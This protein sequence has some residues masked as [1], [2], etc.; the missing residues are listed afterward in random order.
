MPDLMQAATDGPRVFRVGSLV[1]HRSRLIAVFFYLL[2]GG[3]SLSFFGQL[4]YQGLFTKSLTLAGV[5]DAWIS[6]LLGTIPA[7]LN[8]TVAPV[9]SFKSDRLR[10]RFGRR[11]PYIMI[12]IPFIALFLCLLGWA[13]ELGRQLSERSPLPALL[14]SAAGIIGFSFFYMF[15]GSVFYYLY[16]DVVPGTLIG[17]FNA[18]F[19]LV[20]TAAGIGFAHYVMPFAEG[21][22][23]WIYTGISLFAVFAFGVMVW[24]VREGEYPPP[25]P[26]ER[27]LNPLRG[28]LLY[29]RQCFASSRFYWWFFLATALNDV[30]LICRSIYNIKFAQGELGLSIAEFA[31]A[32]KIGMIVGFV[33]TM[34]LGYLV[35]RFNPLRVYAAGM[36]LVIACNC[37]GF[38]FVDDFGSFRWL[39]CGLTVAYTIQNCSTLPLFIALLPKDRY[40]QFCSAQAM[41]KSLVMIGAT[42]L[43]G[44]VV[45][46]LGYRILFLWDAFF[47]L[48]ALLCFGVLY[49]KW[50][51]AGGR[52]GYQA[53]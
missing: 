31:S 38:I 47:T 20:G 17:T 13:P 48:A 5:P 2:L 36:I 32:M 45:T 10:S 9:V 28:S 24:N 18:A 44:V 19:N 29:F 30:S 33:L 41:F 46:M 39:T 14:F 42:M 15:V 50:Q 16:A 7:I 3:F 40:G 52:H 43:A 25:D 11:I 12:S 22:L 49:R 26:A 27:N 4:Q 53:P 23:R 6:I 1:Y 35:D 8:M 51:L 34:P 21:N 37:C